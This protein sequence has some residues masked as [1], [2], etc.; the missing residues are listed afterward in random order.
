MKKR[1]ADHYKRERP[2]EDVPFI[3]QISILISPTFKQ[4]PVYTHSIHQSSCTYPNWRL[5]A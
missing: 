5:N 2:T 1:Q 4:P 3:F